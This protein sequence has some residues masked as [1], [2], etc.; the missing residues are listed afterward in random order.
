[1]KTATYPRAQALKVAYFLG[2]MLAP[3]CWDIEVAGSIRRG[4]AE[5]GDVELVYVPL[6]V[7]EPDGLFERREVPAAA[8]HGTWNM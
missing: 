3:Y 2:D 8:L 6:M 7:S 4:K 5:V 1:M